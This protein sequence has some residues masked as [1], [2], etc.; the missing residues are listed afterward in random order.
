MFLKVSTDKEFM[1]IAR[2]TIYTEEFEKLR[3]IKHHYKV[4]RYEHSVRVAYWSYKIAKK[5]GIDT[6]EIV[7]GALLHD[8]FYQEVGEFTSHPKIALDNAL[9]S[10]QLTDIEQDIIVKHMFPATLHIPKYKESWIVCMVD[11]I[12]AT[13]EFSGLFM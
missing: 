4:N 8:L 11:K 7:V 9:K 10:F 12:C 6:K 1:D 13:I 2:D 5:L 3:D